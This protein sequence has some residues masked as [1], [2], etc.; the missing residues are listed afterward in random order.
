MPDDD[1]LELI[2]DFTFAIKMRKISH[3]GDYDGARSMN[4]YL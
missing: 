1:N 4:S 2:I 3:Y